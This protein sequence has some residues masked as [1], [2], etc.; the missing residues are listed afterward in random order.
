MSADLSASLIFH[1]IADSLC[2]GPL[3][4][5]AGGDVFDLPVMHTSKLLK[6]SHFEYRSRDPDGVMSPVPGFEAWCPNY[7]ALD[8]LGIVAVPFEAG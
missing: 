3:V 1:R 2:A 6:A 5:D 4:M 7:H 8:R